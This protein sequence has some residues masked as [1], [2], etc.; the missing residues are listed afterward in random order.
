M[1]WIR[2]ALVIDPVQGIS[3]ERDVVVNQGKISKIAENISEEEVLKILG[4]KQIEAVR[5]V[6]GVGK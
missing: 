6:N 1:L 3:G 5:Q 4:V 2:K